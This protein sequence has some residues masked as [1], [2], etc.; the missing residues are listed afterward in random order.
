MKKLTLV[1]LALCLAAT[2]A[3][4]APKKKST[5]K[6]INQSKW[7][8]HHIFLSPSNDEDWGPDQLEDEVLA[9]GESLTLT[10]IACGEY[11]VK[12]VD[13]DGDECVIEE[14]ELCGDEAYWKITDKALLEC[15]G[16]S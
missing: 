5:V 16:Y 8:I 4:A 13:E 1:A 15:E 2:A 14:V 6:I 10:G 11:D 12:V 7:E 9:K 3:S